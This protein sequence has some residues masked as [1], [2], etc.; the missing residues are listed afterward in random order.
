M[1]ALD[2]KLLRDFRRLWV[3][4]LAIAL[5][6][7][8]GIMIIIMGM[9]MSRALENT[10]EAY[11]ER[12]RFADIFASVRRAPETVLAAV[13][14]IPGVAAAEGRVSGLVTLDLPGRTRLATGLV[15]SRPVSGDPLLNVPNL[16]SGRWPRENAPDE[17]V[18]SLPFAEANGFVP[19]DRFAANLNGRRRELTVT[20]TAQSPEFIYT[21][22]PGAIMPDNEGYGILWLSAPAAAAIFDM[23]GAFNDLAVKLL[24]RADPGPVIE[25][26]DR[27][28][29]PYGGLAAHDRSKQQSNAFIDAEIHQLGVM[30]WVLPPV[31]LGITVFLVN[32]VIGRIVRLE[33]SEIG[34]MKALGYS[35][36]EICLH[37]L[38]LAA[39]IALVGIAIGWAGGG[40]LSRL[41]AG[42]YAQYFN[43]PY[44][45]YSAPVNVYGWSAAA[46]V[47]AAVLGATRSALAAARL[48]P[49]VAMAP[50]LPPRFNRTALDRML[51]ALG[52]SQPTMMI[53][54]SLLRWPARALFTALGMALAVAVLVATNFFPDSLNEIIDTAFHRTNRQD[55]TLVFSD[56]LPVTAIEAVERLPGVLQAEPQSIHTA[57]LRFG[58]REKTTSIA[59]IPRNGDLARIVDADGNVVEPPEWGLLVPVRLA[60]WLG[61]GVGDLVEVEFQTGRRETHALRVSGLVTQYFGLGVYAN[62][63]VLAKLD[64]ASPG[65]TAANVQL[66]GEDDAAFNAALNA[67]PKLAA[68][69]DM[70]ANRRVFLDTISQNITVITAI[71]AVLGVT[72]TVGVAYNSARVQLSE[73]ARELASLRILGFTRAE[74]SYILAGEIFLLSL[75]AQ[76]IGWWFGA[77]I[78]RLMTENFQN[79]LYELPLVLRAGTFA[80]ASLIVLASSAA[81]VLLVRRRVDRLDLVAVMKTRE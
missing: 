44:L 49:A 10:R 34:L 46:G 31:F 74:V 29:A 17:V 63:D 56:E 68:S 64:R 75:L 6:L 18:V 50:P 12:N 78:A 13:M 59:A 33:R 15:I 39:L 3:Q 66:S 77:A 65:M 8:C 20:G 7:A 35:D 22:G 4:A 37:Y 69:I 38:L 5:V 19:G 1:R 42:I 67:L 16:V 80:W 73:R 57:V 60:R 53:F 51:S 47:A 55:V 36:A 70:A 43:F 40:Y 28:L 25:Q 11:Y 21:I 62:M 24:P 23:S 30:A 27:L 79:D 14:D 61:V 9:G 58:P 52:F 26:L 2:R 71:Y 48:P 32:M 41:M 45:I 54:R 72:M 81:S 76:P